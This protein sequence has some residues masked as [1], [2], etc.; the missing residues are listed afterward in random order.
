MRW[1]PC[2]DHHQLARKKVFDYVFLIA[3]RLLKKTWKFKMHLFSQFRAML[4]SYKIYRYLISFSFHNLYLL[5]NLLNTKSLVCVWV[6]TIEL[7]W[8]WRVVAFDDEQSCKTCTE[9]WNEKLTILKMQ[10]QRDYM[11]KGIQSF[12]KRSEDFGRKRGYL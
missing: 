7:F 12:A 10:W 2:G 4:N 6:P 3:M 1:A 11:W 5:C 9:L 8:G